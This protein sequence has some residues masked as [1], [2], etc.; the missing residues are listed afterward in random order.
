MP[1]FKVDLSDTSEYLGVASDDLNLYFQGTFLKLF[2]QWDKVRGMGRAASSS[3][4]NAIVV[5][6]DSFPQG[7]RLSSKTDV[8]FSFP[9]VGL[10]NYKY[11]VVSFR[12]RSLRQNKKGL[13][14][15][16]AEFFPVINQFETFVEIPAGVK[17]LNAWRW[18]RANL[19][20]VFSED[21]HKE[22]AEAWS[23]IGKRRVVARAVNHD[24]FI[25][26]GITN[27]FPSLWFRQTLI[28]HCPTKDSIVVENTSFLQETLDTFIPQ[29]LDIH[30]V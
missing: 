18:S 11:G 15:G 19:V 30:A 3:N 10:Y 20:G 25:G 28:G 21:N 23:E 2:G 16:T 9:E 26:L 5:E 24:F 29:G 22:F 13:C 6:S 4:P 8:D 27:K 7:K 14:S 1:R 12:R 17:I